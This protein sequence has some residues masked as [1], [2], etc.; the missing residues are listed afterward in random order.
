MGVAKVN[1][2]TSAE[3]CKKQRVMAF[4]TL[5]WYE[6]GEA[7]SPKYTMD[8]TVDALMRYTKQMICRMFAKGEAAKKISLLAKG[9]AGSN[10]TELRGF[11]SKDDS[12]SPH[13]VQTAAA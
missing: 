13:V 12:L 7:V 2:V 4:P 9:T 10:E 8:R 1:C 6:S 11:G 3:L 5:R